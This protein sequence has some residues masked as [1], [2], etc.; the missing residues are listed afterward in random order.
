MV[1]RA[2]A[3][4]SDNFEILWYEFVSIVAWLIDQRTKSFTRWT[5]MW[6]IYLITEAEPK[7]IC[8]NIIPFF[9]KIITLLNFS[10][11]LYH[12][13]ILELFRMSDVQIDSMYLVVALL[14]KAF[15]F[16]KIQ[17]LS[18]NTCKM[19]YQL[20]TMKNKCLQQNFRKHIK[21]SSFPRKTVIFLTS[22]VLKYCTE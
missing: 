8:R 20:S 22:K 7:K 18:N 3:W 19:L 2:I 4:I 9:D 5:L 21:F 15:I 14:E 10:W 17:Y 12:I 11:C 6:G 1:L 16:T 13:D